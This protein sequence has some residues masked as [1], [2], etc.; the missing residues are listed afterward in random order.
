MKIAVI[1]HIGNYGGGSRFVRALLPALKGCREDLDIVF[2]G[3]KGAIRRERLKETLED[4]GIK[5][6][7]LKATFLASTTVLGGE[8]FGSGVRYLQRKLRRKLSFMPAILS[9]QVEREL[10]KTL[11]GFD[12]ALY[13]WPMLL[14]FPRIDCPAVAV[15]HDF[16]F[17]Y[18]FSSWPPYYKQEQEW[19]DETLGVWLRKSR[20]I[21]SSY[22][23]AE[24]LRKFYP[25]CACDASVVHLAPMGST[26]D[27]SDVE[28]NRTRRKNGIVGKYILYPTNI[29]AHKNI[30]PLLSALAILRKM[31]RDVVLVFTGPKTEL[32]NGKACE[33]GLVRGFGDRDVIGLGF[34]PNDEMDSLIAGA[35][36]VVS[37]SLYEAG[38]GPGLEAWANGVPVAMSNIPAFLEHLAVL[39]V[40]AQ[41][42]DPR[43]PQDI[44]EKIDVLLSDP[45][46][47]KAD[48][49]DCRAAVRKYTWK[50]VASQYLEIIEK[51]CRGTYSKGERDAV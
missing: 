31:G 3:N 23:I 1:D 38:N 22:F 14:G 49:M 30:G 9:G 2:Y 44:A 15:F 39:S 50:K 41:V 11:R 51:T 8:E 45:E 29:H 16:N 36:V 13:L 17:K 27:I 42:F 37:T 5:V 19:L 46:K 7:E 40:K 20:P 47:G 28:V 6:R 26:E 12:V 10:E 35:E 43:C 18:F 25:E 33:I 4:S 24:E 34:V 48:A 32:L 21:V